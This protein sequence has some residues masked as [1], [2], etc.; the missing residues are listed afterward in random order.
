M[1]DVRPKVKNP[2]KAKAS[3]QP[4]DRY[5]NIVTAFQIK[6]RINHCCK[7]SQHFFCYT[8]TFKLKCN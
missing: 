1:Q 2:V 6:E 3:I 8:E 7:Y 5:G 4:P